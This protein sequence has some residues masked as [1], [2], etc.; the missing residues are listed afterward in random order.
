MQVMYIMIT[1][2]VTYNFLIVFKHM[3]SSVGY[4]LQVM[5]VE[6]TALSYHW[7]VLLPSGC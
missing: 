1:H 4:V 7:L 5:A 3:V 2:I 6:M